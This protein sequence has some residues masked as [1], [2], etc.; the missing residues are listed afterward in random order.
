MNHSEQTSMAMAAFF[1][2]EE[3]DYWQYYDVQLTG[4]VAPLFGRGVVEA[5][6]LIRTVGA[7]GRFPY[8]AKARA[9]KEN[10]G[11]ERDLTQ[12]QVRPYWWLEHANGQLPEIP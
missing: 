11:F 10:P 3:N 8:E 1:G 7:W 2:G 9:H 4:W 5:Y 12:V 6:K